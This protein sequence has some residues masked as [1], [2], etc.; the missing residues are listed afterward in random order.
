MSTIETQPMPPAGQLIQQGF[1]HWR[2]HQRAFW[3]LAGLGAIGII[4]LKVVIP[5][6][7]SGVVA[8]MYIFLFDQWLKLAMF[9]DWKQREPALRKSK[10]GR[11]LAQPRLSFWVVGFAYAVVVFTAGRLLPCR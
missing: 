10:E 11:R 3:L 8:G 7:S 9:H 2:A 6:G 5:S 4:V 1:Q